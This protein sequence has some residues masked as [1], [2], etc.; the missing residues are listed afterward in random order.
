M[1]TPDTLA[2]SECRYGVDVSDHVHALFGLG[3]FLFA[4]VGKVPRYTTG[5]WR[6]SPRDAPTHQISAC[7]TPDRLLDWLDAPIDGVGIG[8]VPGSVGTV[9]VDVDHGPAQRIVNRCPPLA[10]AHQSRA[11]GDLHGHLVYRRPG[12]P[13][14]AQD[15]VRP[16][17]RRPIGNAPPL[18]APGVRYDVRGDLGYVRIHSEADLE[19]WRDIAERISACPTPS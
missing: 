8:I 14:P 17:P 11:D 9:V 3:A 18:I 16:I 4:A 15:G 19:L 5:G 7:K 1:R 12:G 6:V 13:K 2:V 10:I